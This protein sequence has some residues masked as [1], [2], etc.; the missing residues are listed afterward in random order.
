MKKVLVANRGE[1]A[2]RVMRTLRKME[3][4]SVA[5]YSDADRFAPHV[6][7]ADE[8][9]Y[10][11]PSPSA[12]SYLQQDKIIE[13]CKAL[14][15]D[16]IHP[17][18]GFLSENAGFARKLKAAGIT[19]IGPSPESMEI[20]GDKL[21]AKQAVKGY[22][23]PLV[24]GIDEA[25]TDVSLGKKIAREIGYPVLIK[26]SAGGGGKGMRLVEQEEA[27]E[28][29]MFTAQ[30]EARSS[31]G[32]DAVFIEKFVTK[33]R[34]IEIQ[35]FADQLGNVVYLFER[36]CSIQRRHQKVVEEAPSSIVSESLRKQMGEAAVQVC[37]A[38]SY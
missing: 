23:V 17:G 33:P 18:Y 13:A 35:V 29:Q 34:H 11:G 22:G 24:P 30:S 6:L 12:E 26:A 9:V 31:F 1:I 32:D 28:E 21:S 3:I 5:I 25:V 20:M 7:E 4:E 10:V 37:K 15:V 19:L 16:A 14:G 36:E 27:F 38:C 8:S 2:R